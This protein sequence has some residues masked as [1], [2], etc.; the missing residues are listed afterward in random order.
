MDAPVYSL[1]Y[2]GVR[3]EG[4]FAWPVGGRR[5]FKLGEEVQ[6]SNYM[7]VVRA[8]NSEQ[9]ELVNT[10]VPGQEEPA[11]ADDTETEDDA[12]TP[13]AEPVVKK[14]P[15]TPTSLKNRTK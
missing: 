7:E 1:R 8:L 2:C 3:Q 14:G 13:P 5:A 15:S 11:P 9:F 6:T 10:V 4:L 12:V